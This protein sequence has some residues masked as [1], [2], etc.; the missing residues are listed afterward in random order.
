LK[1]GGIMLLDFLNPF[2]VIPQLVAYEVKEV[3][4]IEFTIARRFSECGFIFKDIRIR[5]NDNEYRFQ[6]KVKAIRSQTFMEYFKK[7]GLE[8]VKIFGNYNLD[9]FIPEES[10]RMVFLLELK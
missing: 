10:E 4:G 3:D 1:C 6:E 9:D 5:H 7:A 2:T 8:L